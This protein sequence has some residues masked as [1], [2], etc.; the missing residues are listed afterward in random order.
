MPRPA[1]WQ[2]M[3]GSNY[4]RALNSVQET[5]AGVSYT[6]AYTRFDEIVSPPESAELHTGPGRITN[7]EI[8]D[9]CPLDPS[10]HLVLSVANATG[11]ALAMDALG[12]DG[13]ANV[14]RVAARGCAQ[15][16]IPG[17]DP[18]GVLLT[19]AGFFAGRGAAD[20]PAEPASRCYVTA[21][22]P[23]ASDRRAR[24]RVAVSPRRAISRRAVRI[25]VSVRVRRGGRLRPVRGATVRA[26]GRRAQTNRRGRA[27][28]RIRFVRP[29]RRLVTARRREFGPGRA[30]VRVRRR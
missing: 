21:S 3:D 24:L 7:V 27:T 26:A 29:G 11:F 23:A 25:R 13:P 19:G 20:V 6:N 14:A 8:Q 10:E 2:Q 4:I 17:F 16:A 18:L 30:V 12:R 15:P 5:F 28:L 22:C 1:Q 9:I